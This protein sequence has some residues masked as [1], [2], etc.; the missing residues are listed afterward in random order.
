L[1]LNKYYS[2]FVAGFNPGTLCFLKAVYFLPIH[3]AVV[4]LLL[5]VLDIVHLVV[6]MN[7]YI[8]KKCT[9]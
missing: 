5:H 6:L 3:V 1:K 9:E 7:E 4:Y 8:D 2:P